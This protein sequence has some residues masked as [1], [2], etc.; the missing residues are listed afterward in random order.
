MGPVH[1]NYYAVV[2]CRDCEKDRK[3]TLAKRQRKTRSN[4]I[5]IKL[6]LKGVPINSVEVARA[7]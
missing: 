6:D 1:H 2:R 5:V 7:R 3:N 4:P